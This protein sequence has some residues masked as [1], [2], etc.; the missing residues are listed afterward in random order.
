MAKIYGNKISISFDVYGC[1]QR[2]KHCW[3][4]QPKHSTMDTDEV[5]AT[6]EYIKNEQNRYHYFD[7]EVEYLD[8]GLREPHY[9]NDYK[10][11]YQK[12]DKINRCSLEK[13]FA[14]QPILSEKA[15]KSTLVFS[16]NK[17]IRP[18]NHIISIR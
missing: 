17:C 10:E 7:A 18:F 15:K 12:I 3:L 14:M 13:L 16:I 2:C 5:I 1:P 8:V 9:G 4:G 11:L 6:F